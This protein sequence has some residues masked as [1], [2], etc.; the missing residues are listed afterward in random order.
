MSKT[1]LPVCAACYNAALVGFGLLYPFYNTCISSVCYPSH[2][3]FTHIHKVVYPRLMMM[4]NMI[5]ELS[6]PAAAARRR[7]RGPAP[8]PRGPSSAG[9]R[10]GRGTP[11]LHMYVVL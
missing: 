7:P 9:P 4:M 1:Y 6:H 2:I 5:S 3:G 11:L 10:L 8:A